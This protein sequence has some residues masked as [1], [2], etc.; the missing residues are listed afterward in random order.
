[1]R[2]MR[3]TK[4]ADDAGSQKRFW[5][6]IR[7][8]ATLNIS[9]ERLAAALGGLVALKRLSRGSSIRYAVLGSRGVLLEFSSDSATATY[10]SDAPDMHDRISATIVL[11]SALAYA[12]GAYTVRFESAYETIIDVLRQCMMSKKP[13]DCVSDVEERLSG[14]VRALSSANASLSH[15]VVALRNG[16]LD[17]AASRDAYRELCL[18]FAGESYHGSIEGAVTELGIGGET[19]ERIRHHEK[20]VGHA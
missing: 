7:V 15:A 20:G 3:H 18:R 10:Y 12:K 1:M 9:R 14:R 4:K 13:N 11:L 8:D 16:E 17:A 19:A 2:G 5:S 6:T